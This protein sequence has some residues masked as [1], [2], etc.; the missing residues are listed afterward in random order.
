MALALLLVEPFHVLLSLIVFRLCLSGLSQ[1][2]YW[3]G[4][5]RL[6]TNL[7][8]ERGTDGPTR[9]FE[10]RSDPIRSDPTMSAVFL[11]QQVALSF[12]TGFLQ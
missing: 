4:L 1:A 11:D 5:I 8:R 10:F 12:L 3:I 9:Y 2:A 7:A 6:A